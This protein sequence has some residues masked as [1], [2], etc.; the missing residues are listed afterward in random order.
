MNENILKAVQAARASAKKRNFSQSFD[1][2]VNLKLIDIKKPENR[3]NEIFALPKSRGKVAEVVFFTDSAKDVDCTI[4]NSN[5]IDRLARSKREIKKIANST[6]FFLSEPKL[7]PAIGKSLGRVLAPRGKMPTVVATDQKGVIERHKKSI[8][9]KVKD[10]PVIQCI[11]GIESMKDEDVAENIEAVLNFL[12]KKLPKGKNSIGKS[13][14]KLTMGK[15]AE[16][17]I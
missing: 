15:P 1:L 8:R 5:D 10:S 4:Y 12:E 11:V 17:E 9:I 13:L 7:M 6:D 16:L 14:I 3:I 2:I